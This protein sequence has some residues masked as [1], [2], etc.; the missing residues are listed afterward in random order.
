MSSQTEEKKEIKRAVIVLYVVMA[1][2][3]ML[4]FLLLLLLRR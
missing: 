4:P 1:I 2:G 3:I